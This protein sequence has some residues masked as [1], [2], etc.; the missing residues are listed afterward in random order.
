[1]CSGDKLRNLKEVRATVCDCPL[2]PIAPSSGVSDVQVAKIM[3]ARLVDCLRPLTEGQGGSQDPPQ[4]TQ[5]FPTIRTC[6]SNCM[7]A[8]GLSRRTRVYGPGKTMDF[9]LCNCDPGIIPAE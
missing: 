9:H 6:N 5:L 4:S 1:M 2:S 8:C 3:P 7:E